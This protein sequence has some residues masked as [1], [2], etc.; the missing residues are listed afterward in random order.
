MNLAR[1]AR[2]LFNPKRFAIA[3]YLYARGPTT[4]AELRKVTGLTWGDLDSNIRYLEKHGLAWTRKDATPQGPRTFI[5]LTEKG[6]QAFNQ[7]TQYLHQTLGR[8]QKRQS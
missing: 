7:L 6:V 3:V 5:G 1:E 8:L 2:I 4:M